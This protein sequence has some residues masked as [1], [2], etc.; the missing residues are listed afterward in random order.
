MVFRLEKLLNIFGKYSWLTLL[1]LLVITLGAASQL[2]KVEVQVSADE[3]LVKN[4]PARDFYEKIGQT[5]GDEQVSLLFLEDEQLLSKEKLLTLESVIEELKGL[6]YIQRIESLFS[7]PHLRTVDGYLVKDPYLNNLP[8][9]AEAEQKLLDQALINPFLKHVLLSEDRQVMAVAIV[10]K[11]DSSETQ[12]RSNDK[13]ITQGIEEVTSQLEGS[14]ERFFTIGFPYV[15]TEISKKITQEQGNLIPLA[16]AALLIALFL[17]LRQLLD[18]LIPILT[19]GISIIWILGA[20]G[21]LGIPLTVVTSIVPILL[22]I[23]GSTEDIHLLSEFRHGQSRGLST[24]KALHLMSKK[25]GRTILLTF[26]TTYLGFLAVGLSRIEVLWEFGLVA[27]T[28]LLLNFIATVG[29]IPALLSIAGKWQLDG[30]PGLLKPQDES[31][32]ERY[33]SKLHDSK[34][35]VTIIFGI[36]ALIAAAGI[37]NINLNHSTIDSLNKDS[38]VRQQFEEVNERLAGLE[39]FSIIVDSGIDD[40]FLKVRYIEELVAI[41]EFLHKQG[42]SRSSTSFADYLSL[43]NAAFEEIEQPRMPD[44][45]EMVNELM[46][47][48]NYEH[49]KA[50]VSE[51]YRTA[52]I[53]VRHNVSDTEPLQKMLN[54]VQAFVEQNVDSGLETRITGDSVL[55]L[56]ATRAMIWGQL[57]SIILLVIIIIIIVSLLFADLKVGLLMAIPNIFPVLILFGFMGY[58]GI[59]LNI[60]TTMAAAIA[61]GIA[62]DDTMH[63]MLRYNRELKTSK[64]QLRALNATIYSEALPV[65][66]TSF[67]L[68]AGF[69]VFSLSDFKPIAQFGQLS[70]LV[71]FAALIADFVITPIMISTLRLVTLWDIISLELRD[72]VISK[73]LLFK[74]MKPRQIRRFILSSSMLRYRPNQL[75]FNEGDAADTM[76]MIMTGAVEIK[77][78]RQTEG[79]D[80]CTLENADISEDGKT[81]EKNMESFGPGEIFGEVALLAS[82]SRHTHAVATENTSLLMLSRESIESA[83]ENYPQIAAKLFLNLSTHVSHRLVRLVDMS[84][85]KQP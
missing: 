15:R 2:H 26:I 66:A 17:L 62:V 28:G 19:S 59:P 47:F 80:T 3:L 42:I 13:T 27:S 64:S 24:R 79:A 67:A 58:V 37:P 83:T 4:D 49:V 50:Y 76:Y 32:A 39:S 78:T 40:T 84:I 68:I 43:L 46:I 71:I 41:Q 51:D 20:M 69:L 85:G 35:P 57:Q 82:D 81:F 52:R 10:L 56:S 38:H 6:P 72:E 65:L 5:F 31:L 1:A 9:T 18:I 30:R 29:L 11:D 21:A 70:A 8:D 45:D 55:S 75:I 14:Y 33:W 73:S 77:L 61:I 54:E 12:A 63:F 53:L 7:T 22:I 36:I 25:M 23:V 16:I 34:R 48:L 74:G 60:G 44:S